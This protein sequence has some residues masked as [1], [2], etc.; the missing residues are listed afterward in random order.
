M[1]AHTFE[2][3][4]AIPFIMWRDTVTV[5]DVAE[6][7]GLT[8]QNAQAAIHRLKK[9]DVIHTVTR[10]GGATLSVYRYGPTPIPDHPDWVPS[11]NMVDF[12]VSLTQANRA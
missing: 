2:A 3:T 5:A 9:K 12:L 7:F 11:R 10:G 8:F 4:T 6:R 1:S